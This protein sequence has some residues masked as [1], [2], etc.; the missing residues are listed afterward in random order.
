M[1]SQTAERVRP[2]NVVVHLRMRLIKQNLHRIALSQHRMRFYTRFH[3]NGNAW[4]LLHIGP[5]AA[6]LEY[7]Y[8]NTPDGD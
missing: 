4:P 6:I 7:K 8:K 1:T 5:L 2:N 3:E